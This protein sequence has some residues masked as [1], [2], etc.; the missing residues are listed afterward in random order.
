MERG[1]K[2]GPKPKGKVKIKWSAN[3]A[4]AIGL[5]A[6]D[7]CLSPN[8]RHIILTSVDKE[9]LENYLVKC[10]NIEVKLGKKTNGHGQTASVIQFSDVLF[11]DFLQSIGITKAKSL[12][13]G[14]IAIPEIIPEDF[15]RGCFDGD[16]HTYS[17]WD[18]RWK[19]SFMFYVGFTSASKDFIEWIREE[20]KIE[21]E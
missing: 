12:T 7:G 19:S 3:F 18:P 17:Y 5:L 2:P 10:L 14:K 16:G 8:G 21:L 15:L 9:Q 4:Y 6:T 1:V 11:F 13:M 20:I